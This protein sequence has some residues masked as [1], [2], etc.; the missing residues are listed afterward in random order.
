MRARSFVGL[1]MLNGGTDCIKYAT[2]TKAK[3][4]SGVPTTVRLQLINPAWDFFGLRA[5]SFNW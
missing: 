1:A 4:I 3:Q 2:Y 5:L